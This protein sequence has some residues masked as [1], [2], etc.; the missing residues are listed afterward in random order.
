MEETGFIHEPPVMLFKLRNALW[1]S[2]RVVI[3]C[4]LH[5]GDMTFEEA[6]DLLRSQVCLDTH[7]AEGEVRRYTTHNNPTY[8]SSYLV[9]K[10]LIQGL[11]QQWLEQQGQSRRLKDFHN[12]LLGYGSPPVKFVAQRMAGTP[13]RPLAGC[14]SGLSE[15]KD[16]YDG[17]EVDG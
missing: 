2:V 10:M 11:R 8:P 9:G 14:G 12:Q 1:R 6:V 13:P 16:D 15:P 3:D 4:G 5:A 17:E 7:M